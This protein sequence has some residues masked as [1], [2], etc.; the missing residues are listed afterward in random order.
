MRGTG[1]VHCAGTWG[2]CS[3]GNI[4]RGSLTLGTTMPSERDVG[5]V[6]PICPPPPIHLPTRSNGVMM[7]PETSIVPVLLGSNPFQSTSGA[8]LHDWKCPECAT[9]TRPVTFQSC[10]AAGSGARRT[11]ESKM[12]RR[13]GISRLGFPHGP[14]RAGV[15]VEPRDGV[16]CGRRELSMSSA[17]IAHPN[18]L[19]SYRPQ[20][21]FLN[22]C[23]AKASGLPV[24][25]RM[26]MSPGGLYP[27]RLVVMAQCATSGSQRSWTLVRQSLERLRLT[28]Q[29]IP[30]GLQGGN[31]E[32]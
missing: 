15:A 4:A 22:S 7:G 6:R 8:G 27:S 31:G 10:T 16:E 30:K 11:V 5:D 13:F 23:G 12:K 14:R 18:V 2:S 24:E 17:T 9:N 20:D 3:S 1:A 26:Y 29:C 21:L 28:S 32:M 25:D 19:T